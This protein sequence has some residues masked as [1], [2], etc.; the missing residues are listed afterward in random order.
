MTRHLEAA[1]LAVVAALLAVGG[2]TWSFDTTAAGALWAAA[3]VVMLA[4]TA[5]WVVRDLRNR[6]YGADLLAVL[7]LGGTLAV[8]EF[9]A[10]GVIAL[11]VATGRL[12]EASAQ[13]RAG[14]DLAA[15]MERAPTQAHVRT[16]GG[17]DT[18]AAASVA[19]GDRVVVLAGEIVPVDGTLVEGGVLDESALTGESAVVS[20]AAGGTVRSGVVNAGAAVDLLATATA[21]GSTY[22][23][24]VKLAEQAAA[25]T[26]PVA[27]LADRVAV[28]FLPLALLIAGVAWAL[29]GDPVRAVA[30]LVTATP[31]PLLLAVPVAVTGGM[32]RMSRSGVVVKGGAALEL[33]G[34]ATTLLMDKTGTVTGGRP[35]VTDVVCAPDAAPEQV[36]AVAAGVEQYSHHL[37]AEAVVRAA[38]RAGATPASAHAVTED[39]GR[40]AVGTVDGQLVRVGRA[41]DP[42][43][44]PDWARAAARR[45]RLDLASV[46]WVEVGGEP[47][48]ALLVRDPIRPD[49]ARTMRRLREVGLERIVLLTGDRV[50]NAEEVA[51]LLG[52]DEVRAE[53]S[54]ADKIARVRAESG[55][56]TVMVG[57]GIND[58]PALAAAGVGIALG[59][60]G[61]TAAV[62]AADA[63]IVDDRIDRLADGVEAARRT[64]AIALQSAI[65]GTALSVLAMLAAAFGLLV[66]VAGALVQE[67]IDVAVILNALRAVRGGRR[68]TGARLDALLE[69]FA[70]EHDGLRSARTAVRQAADALAHGLGPVADA[71]VGHAYRLLQDELLPHEHAEETVLY[72]AL[73]EV[74]GGPE[75]TVTMSRAHGEIDRLARRIGRHLAE[76]GG[77]IKADQLDDLRATLYG[78]DAILTLH[79]AQEEEAYFVL[80]SGDAKVTDEH[81]H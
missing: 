57:D 35:E 74:L 48:A 10:G 61:S 76:S 38:R 79:F 58:A 56:V 4:P 37:M 2:I 64:R 30:V 49:A 65:A 39:P 47:K 22:A 18:V 78:L 44:L 70:S 14:R 5:G 28:W 63:V 6:R 69:R 19:P 40:A 55:G 15:L 16:D 41:S 50:D 27:R 1:L 31:C 46:V 60:R 11:M 24:V 68:K 72:P 43:N 3:T 17:I 25:S 59:S 67:G 34:H 8:G 9:L 23:G 45:G 71:A 80:T 77:V 7:A 36:L 20:R 62:Q 51:R 33:L 54:P 29:S 32:S 52:I 66:P 42:E 13:R 75:S 12:L 73:A 21:A 81:S 53:A 26:A